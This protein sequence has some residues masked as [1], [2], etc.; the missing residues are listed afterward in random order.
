[1]HFV[2][3]S[4]KCRASNKAIL[5]AILENSKQN[6]G[7]SMTSEISWKFRPSDKAILP[8]FLGNF[9]QNQGTLLA[10][11][12]EIS[13]EIGKHFVGFSWKFRAYFE[14]LSWLF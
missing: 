11:L 10:S 6:Q 7:T 2:G 14:A 1:M 13:T 3:F 4:S 5:L 8:A 12:V 9:E